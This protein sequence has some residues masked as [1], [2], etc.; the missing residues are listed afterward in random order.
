MFKQVF[1]KCLK[2]RF[3]RE[4]FL[5]QRTERY[6]KTNTKATIVIGIMGIAQGVGTTHL[7]IMVGNYLANGLGNKVAIVELG[8][9]DDYASFAP[10]KMLCDDEHK[11]K[12]FTSNGME[13]YESVLNFEVPIILSK[14]YDYVIFDIECSNVFGKNQFVRSDKKIV[15]GSLS[16]WKV[17]LYEQFISDMKGIEGYKDCKYVS[18][19]MVKKCAKRIEHDHGIKIDQIPFDDNPFHI[20]C[21][22]LQWLKHLCN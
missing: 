4:R 15:I 14:N 3:L 1:I 19:T 7:S 6:V 17:N 5:K 13:F 11:N 21:E 20:Q 22:N 8:K 18:L 16:R 2:I 9:K 10:E 12:H